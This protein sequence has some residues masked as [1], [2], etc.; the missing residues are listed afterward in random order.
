MF[1]QIEVATE[2]LRAYFALERLLVIV[3][4]HVECQIVDLMK[5][6]VTNLTFVR[7][8]ARV[9]QFVILVIPLLMEAL[10]AE[11]ADVRLVPIV[12]SGVG[13]EG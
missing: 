11:L 10:A 12:N 1:L 7:L 6:L 2:S 5:R 13:V 8:L 3:R 4:V 9:R